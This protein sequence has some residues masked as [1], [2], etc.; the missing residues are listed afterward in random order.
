M[1]AVNG[2][3]EGRYARWDGVGKPITVVS[4]SGRPIPA[5]PSSRCPTV[6][7]TRRGRKRPAAPV[8]DLVIGDPAEAPLVD[9]ALE[10]SGHPAA[11]QA[12]ITH[13]DVGGRAVLAGSVAAAPCICA[14]PSTSSLLTTASISLSHSVIR[15]TS[16]AR[17]AGPGSAARR[18][19]RAGSSTPAASSRRSTTSACP[20]A[21]SRDTL[22]YGFPGRSWPRSTQI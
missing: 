11:V 22:R 8:A 15:S 4:T 9:V 19:R 5:P 12:C 14:R 3:V 6:S 16:T 7:R 2:A 21:S 13:L 17:T 1:T 20:R 18:R 10:L